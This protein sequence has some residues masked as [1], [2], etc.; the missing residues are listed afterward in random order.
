MLNPGGPGGSGIRFMRGTGGAMRLLLDSPDMS[1]DAKFYDLISFDPRGLGH[2]TPNVHCFADADDFR[3]WSTKLAQEGSLTSSDRSL[4]S[5][6]AMMQAVG[7]SCAK[8]GSDD[9]KHYV[10]TASV[11][12]D[13]LALT[14]AHG[15]W[16]ESEAER[17]LS[18]G[19]RGL[20]ST[21]QALLHK[22]G[23]E[24][25][26]Y[27]GFSYGTHIGATFAA[28]YP[29][30]IERFVLDGVMDAAEYTT[31]FK[32]NSLVDI[33]KALGLFFHHCA[34]V[35][36]SGC[37]FADEGMTAANISTRFEAVINKLRDYPLPVLGTNPD[38]ITYTILVGEV[39]VS[40]Y[41]PIRAW[42]PLAQ[43]LAN[44]EAGQKVGYIDQS[45][46][47]VSEIRL[48]MRSDLH[49]SHSSLPRRAP[50]DTV[51]CSGRGPAPDKLKAQRTLEN[52]LFLQYSVVCS[53]SDPLTHLSRANFRQRITRLEE[54]SPHFGALEADLYLP[55]TGWPLRPTYRHT[56]PWAGN[57]SNPILWVGNTADPVCPLPAAKKM[58]ERFPGSGLLTVNGPGHC[59][60]AVPS[61][62]A[63]E[64]IRRYFHTGELPPEGTVCEPF[65]VPFGRG[66]NETV[67][68]MAAPIV[69]Q[70]RIA[71]GLGH[72]SVYAARGLA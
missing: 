54:E 25:V 52:L 32:D 2:S 30:R 16:R 29:D 34:R 37:A 9:I 40:M 46:S 12:A 35:G 21:P 18:A 70:E 14:E 13:L 60:V 5:Q 26:Q 1:T 57:T 11:A 71:E 33:E 72:A 65:A 69:A 58:S 15:A 55:C 62:E 24:R 64:Y 20:R 56:G 27:Y 63:V 53:D 51:K 8:V 6:W 10:S 39:F 59:S 36:P 28:M 68:V 17:L 47:P 44:I 66:A 48:T 31:A 4:S 23:E 67:G 3:I 61:L 19:P 49:F 41:N 45:K 38:I 7:R 22:A 42:S 43:L 50:A